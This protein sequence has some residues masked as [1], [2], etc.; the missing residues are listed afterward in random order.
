MEKN[1]LM[2][3]DL[4]QVNLLIHRVEL[5]KRTLKN[6]SRPIGEELS[7]ELDKCIIFRFLLATFNVF[8]EQKP[9]TAMTKHD[10]ETLI[11]YMFKVE[12]FRV[13]IQVYSMC[14]KISAGW[15]GGLKK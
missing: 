2:L 14:L 5:F 12:I 8:S 11:P 6:S 9:L 4:L 10:T 13:A 3:M 1:C 15:R 7:K